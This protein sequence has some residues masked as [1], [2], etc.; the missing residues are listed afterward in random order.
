MCNSAR[1]SKQDLADVDGTP[2][3][4]FVVEDGQILPLPMFV[5]KTT[6]DALLADEQSNDAR[7]C[8]QQ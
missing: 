1:K 3:V 2:L 6:L 8:Q 5:T 4:Q 7:A